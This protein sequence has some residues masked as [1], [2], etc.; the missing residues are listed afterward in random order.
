MW[1]DVCTPWRLHS[2]HSTPSERMGVPMDGHQTGSE[3]H[4]SDETNVSNGIDDGI[5]GLQRL[6]ICGIDG[7]YDGHHSIR[8]VDCI[9]TGFCSA[10]NG[11]DIQ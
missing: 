6:K 2:T 3:Q 10:R 4:S 7:I 8:M 9:D 11:I 5:E 1:Y